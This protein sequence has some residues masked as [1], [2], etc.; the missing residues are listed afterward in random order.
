MIKAFRILLYPFAGIAIG[1]VL[2]TTMQLVVMIAIGVAV[3]ICLEVI[4]TK[5]SYGGIDLEC[6]EDDL[7]VGVFD[8]L[9]YFYWQGAVDAFFLLLFNTLLWVFVGSQTENSL[10]I[11][12]DNVS[13]YFGGLI[14][15]IE[16]V[17]A[18]SGE[19]RSAYFN[20]GYTY[21][22]VLGVLTFMPTVTCVGRIFLNHLVF[23]Q[24]GL[25]ARVSAIMARQGMFSR[26]DAAKHIFMFALLTLFIS[27]ALFG[28][29]Y[30]P[31]VWWVPVFDDYGFGIR[32]HGLF[33]YSVGIV[34]VS[35]GFALIV[36]HYFY[37]LFLSYSKLRQL[38]SARY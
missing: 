17:A 25:I 27:V 3:S 16:K 1:I 35:S 37:L 23:C 19:Q 7:P 11:I 2:E 30:E 31:G 29:I 9:S 32:N 4:W 10:N 8:G 18:F 26:I 22:N 21:L 33:S 6:L 38:F 15:A 14:P 34:A 20:K 24:S 5:T 12:I 28:S 36:N 13:N